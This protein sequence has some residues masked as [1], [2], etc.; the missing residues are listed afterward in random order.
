[1]YHVKYYYNLEQLNDQFSGELA[2]EMKLLLNEPRGFIGLKGCIVVP[3]IHT[4]VDA[5]VIFLIM[6]DQ[7]LF[8]TEVLSQS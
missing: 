5:A 4:E 7:F 6:K 2:E 1:M 3:S 8:I